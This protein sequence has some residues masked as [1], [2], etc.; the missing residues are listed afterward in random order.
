MVLGTCVLLST[1]LH[2]Y[3]LALPGFED[4][5]RWQIHWGKRVV[6]EGVWKLY[7]GDYSARY[8]KFNHHDIVD[9]P[10]VVP[11]IVGGLV[12]LAKAWHQSE[13]LR[14]IIK[15]TVTVFEVTLIALL[16]WLTVTHCPAPNSHR[17]FVGGLILLN[18]GLALATTGW[19]Q[20]DSLLCL[21]I[22]LAFY[23]GWND[24]FWLST[25]L[26][27]AAVLTKPQG[28]IALAC[29]YVML[30][31]RRKYQAFWIQNA[32]GFVLLVSLLLAWKRPPPVDS[33]SKE[34]PRC[35]LLLASSP[36]RVRH[37]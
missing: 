22:V 10:P 5:L 27:L 2:I 8:G 25:P 17:L 1:C 4:D 28:V 15:F 12:K 21:F 20:I 36:A 7:E 23:F 16:F 24:R 37:R 9:Y 13:R 14:Q 34:L 30:L 19:G 35:G 31:A 29:Y 3:F 33:S 26:I 6:K 32:C 18:P 11:L